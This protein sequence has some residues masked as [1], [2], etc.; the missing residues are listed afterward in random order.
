[1]QEI[2]NHLYSGKDLTLDESYALFSHILQGDVND[3]VLAS[4]LTAL[5]IKGENCN[6]LAGASKAML[7]NCIKLNKPNYKVGEIV[8]TGGDGFNTI[9]ISTISAI[10]ASCANLKIAKHGNRAVSSKTGASDLLSTLG[11]NVNLTSS[12]TLDLLSSEGF[13]FLFAPVYHQAMKY[14]ANVRKILSVRTIFNL[15]GPLCNPLCPDFQLIGVYD[16]SLTNLL[17]HTMKLNGAKRV[18]CVCGS[19]LDEISAFNT[20]YVTELNDG[21]LKDYV[22]NPKDFGINEKLDFNEII[23][24]DPQ[25]NA[26]IAL[27]ILK[28]NGTYTQNCQI[29]CNLAALFYLSD[30]TKNLKDGFSYAMGIITSGV[31][32]TKLHNILKQ[33]A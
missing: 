24:G 23:G 15:L 27:N 11:Y 19:G 21:E 8:G 7:N 2:L 10:L 5:K 13:A 4:I 25:E 28:G 6:E 29:A 14:A 16:K 30:T 22:L 31:G 1:M 17:A 3:I 32:I 20:T 18:M 12:K 33:A 9:N 26:N